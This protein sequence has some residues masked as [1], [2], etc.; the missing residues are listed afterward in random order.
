MTENERKRIAGIIEA[1]IRENGDLLLSQLKQVLKAKGFSDEFLSG[2]R[3]KTWIAGE[4]PEFTIVGPSGGAERIAIADKALRLI[5][6][7]VAKEG[8]FL[9]SQVS[10]LLA[11]EGIDWKARANGKKLREWITSTYPGVFEVSQ[12]ALW[13]YPASA[14]P[15]PAPGPAPAPAPASGPNVDAATKSYAYQFCFFPANPALLRQVRE[16]TG[17]EAMSNAKWAAHR[18][19]ALAQCLLGLNGGMLDDSR[20]ESPR[21]AFR[22][23]L[24][25]RHEQ[26]IYGIMAPNTNEGAS[27]KWIFSA[28]A[29]PGQDTEEGYWLCNTFG[30]RSQASYGDDRANAIN[31]VTDTLKIVQDAQ[32]ALSGEFASIREEVEE[33]RMLSEAAS[34]LIL[35]YIRGWSLLKKA[36]EKLRES[37]PEEA[38]SIYSVQ[39]L[40]DEL[41]DTN[42]I[43]DELEERFT[44][45]ARAVWGFLQDN[46]LCTENRSQDDAAAWSRILRRNLTGETRAEL[47]R[48]LEP[49][50]AVA[51]LRAFDPE[52]GS[53]FDDAEYSALDTV[54]EHFGVRLKLSQLRHSICSRDADMSFLDAIPKINALIL[55][56]ASRNAASPLEEELPASDAELLEAAM[57][58]DLWRLT[59]RVFRKPNRLETAVMLGDRE[60]VLEIIGDPEKLSSFGYDP[61]YEKQLAGKAEDLQLSRT[62]TPLHA[63]E[64]LLQVM[65]DS[66]EA[67]D[68]CLLLSVM[69]KQEGAAEVLV[70][71]YLDTG[72]P[73]PASTLFRASARTMPDESRRQFTLSLIQAGCLSA[74]EAI[75][76]DILVFLTEE[77]IRLLGEASVGEE[78][79]ERMTAIYEKIQPTP[80]RY[81]VFLNPELQSYILR[82]ENAGELK[83]Y[84][85]DTHSEK[86]AALLRQNAFERGST[87]LQ[88][89][90]RVHAFMGSWGDLALAFAQ[91]SAESPERQEF[92]FELLRE[93]GDELR[94]IR[95]LED[96]PA[97]RQESIPYYYELLF[98]NGDY[99]KLCLAAEES[100]CPSTR[101]LLLVLLASCRAGEPIGGIS[102]LDGAAA[103][104]DQLLFPVGDELYRRDPQLHREFLVK[105][106]PEAVQLFN[107]EELTHLVTADGALS[108]EALYRMAEDT[109]RACPPLALYCGRILGTGDFAASGSPYLE[110]RFGILPTLDPIGQKKAAHELRIL[111]PEKYSGLEEDIFDVML[112]E[113]LATETDADAKARSISGLLRNSDLGVSTLRHA[114]ARIGS[115]PVLCRAPLYQTLYA[116]MENDPACA[117]LF[118][119][120]YAF[121]DQ[122]DAEYRTFFCSR[123]LEADKRAPLP[124]DLL[125][126][127]ENSILE[128]SDRLDSADVR[129]CILHIEE[130]RGREPYLSFARAIAEEAAVS[131]AEEYYRTS[132]EGAAGEVS[133]LCDALEDDSVEIESYLQ[134]CARLIAS[135]K[136]RFELDSLNDDDALHALRRL[137]QDPMLPDNWDAVERF[138]PQSRIR[139]RGLA[140]Y[141][142]A[143]Y[144]GSLKTAEPWGVEDMRD[145][146]RGESRPTSAW[147]RC[148]NYCITEDLDDLFFRSVRS[149]LKEINDYYV[150]QMP[151]YATKSYMQTMQ[152]I[153]EDSDTV[154]QGEHA[155][156]AAFP[157]C[158]RETAV[159]FISEAIDVFKRIDR[160]KTNQVS[161]DDNHNS[162][163]VIIELSLRLGC[164][165]LLLENLSEELCGG[166][167]NL[168]LVVVCRL[169]LA[170]K[171]DTAMRFLHHII[172]AAVKEYNY[173]NLMNRLAAMD[174]DEELVRWLSIESNRATLR[175]ILPNGNAPDLLRLQT[176]VMSA[177]TGE[178]NT[179]EDCARVVE[180]LIDCYPRDVMC[181]KSLF[182]ICKED[183]PAHL[184]RIYRSLVGIYK[185]YHTKPR[186]MYTRDRNQILQ[187]IA[188]LQQVMEQLGETGT[189]FEPVTELI[190]KYPHENDKENPND[191]VSSLNQLSEDIRNLFVGVSSGSNDFTLMIRSLMGS[192]TENWAP[193]F[194]EAFKLRQSNWLRTYCVDKFRTT[195]G[196]LRGMLRVWQECTSDAEKEEYLAWIN[197]EREREP[198]SF[199]TKTG[200]KQ[201]NNLVTKV[202]DRAV[203]WT[204]LRL[205]WEEHL[206]CLG[207]LKELSRPEKNCC[208]KVMMAER[209]KGI[210]A[211]DSFIVMIRLAQDILK[212]QL[213]EGNAMEWFR[214]GD[215]DLAAAAYEALDITKIFPSRDESRK[216]AY[217]E[218]YETWLRLSNIFAGA[219]LGTKSCSPHSCMNMMVALINSGFAKHFDRL[220]P[221]LDGRNLKLFRVVRRILTTSLNDGEIIEILSEFYQNHER[222]SLIALL[223]FILSAN[224][225]GQYLILSS[226]DKIDYAARQLASLESLQSAY[227]RNKYWI[228]LHFRP[229]P[230]DFP[231][232]ADQEDDY[233][234]SEAMVYR[235]IETADA[236]FVPRFSAEI[237]AFAAEDDG[238]DAAAL[239]ESYN[240]LTPYTDSDGSKRLRLA[241]LLCLRGRNTAGKAVNDK[242]LVRF[243][244]NYYRYHYNCVRQGIEPEVNAERMHNAMLDLATYGLQTPGANGEIISYLPN[245]F[246]Y[247][248]R[249]YSTIDNLLQD[250]SQ[251][252]TAYSSI[253]RLLSDTEYSDAAN[254]LLE[255]LNIL[256]SAASRV[257]TDTL[258]IR[259]CQLAQARLSEVTPA[260]DWVE[261]FA[262]LNE[263]LRQAINRLD[264]RPSLKITLFNR[265]TGLS[266]DGLYGEI[267]NTGRETA[268]R[269]ELQATFPNNDRQPV[270]P[271]YRLPSLRPNEKAAFAVSYQ[272]S[273]TLNELEY[274]LN[275]SYS[276]K[277]TRCAAA[278]LH[279]R[280]TLL[281]SQI[282]EGTSVPQFNTSV[283]SAFTID[284]NGEIVSEDFK[285]RKSET[286]SLRALLA[287][288]D[289]AEYRSAIV[290]GIKR[291]GKTSLLNYLRA[292]IRAKKKENTVQLF[293][294][295]QAISR[296][297][298]YKAFFRSVLDELP[299]EFPQILNHPGWPDFVSRWK[300]GE[301]EEGDR[302]PADLSLFFRQLHAMM[303]GK[304]LYLIFDEFDVLIDRLAGD[305]GYDPL[306]QALRSLQMN[307]DCRDAVHLV[308]CGSNHLLIYNR[309]GSTV[310]QMFQSFEPIP[311]GQMLASDIQEMIRDWLD[312]YPFIR[313]AEAEGDGISPSIQ[314]IERYTGGLVWYTRLLVNEAVRTAFRDSRECV[315]PSDICTAFNSICCYN[316]CR[317]LA[318]GCGANEKIVLDAMQALA[319][320]PGMFV[321]Y[322]QLMQ[323]LD[324]T[325][326]PAQVKE[327]LDILTDSVQL[328]EQKSGSRSYRFRVEL[329]RRYFRTR[330][331]LENRESRFG[332]DKD[333][334]APAYRDCFVMDPT[335]VGIETVDSN[336]VFN[337][338][339]ARRPKK[340]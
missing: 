274:I 223:H 162:L 37:R 56:A 299:L 303:D 313:F 128:M 317:Q 13:V 301:E 111:D 59:A 175:F 333:D 204:M 42:Q 46:L 52:G 123:V 43:Q 181:Y 328:L 201:L 261:M 316:N 314:W 247:C 89:A 276:D 339:L 139:A 25:T 19:N 260:R 116:L 241:A 144:I 65:G 38:D 112:S 266:S 177:Y 183:Y 221:C 188:V 290:Q 321:S 219:G 185:Y 10:P 50:Q 12:D 60:T 305:T 132:D 215:Y 228:P 39:K 284:E 248:V 304:G 171:R 108:G 96:N 218:S 267:E 254:S 151:W 145:D 206:V 75:N 160:N 235:V 226:R 189:V 273:E 133:L 152:K 272:A 122:G 246:Q 308:L 199:F 94:M 28:V 100:G 287:G 172:S 91:F 53:V 170:D 92:L 150:Q 249:S 44:E 294:D 105:V 23:G 214:R 99:A 310:N 332:A 227:M 335:T 138:I 302:D 195:R 57:G 71:H 282:P 106:F 118:R 292:F 36:L 213:L 141:Y 289:F 338:F 78:V 238:S 216:E 244:I 209:L 18:T 286:Q 293:I 180:N 300:L 155:Q 285:G 176:L 307:P 64:R 268:N 163:R 166:Y 298:I 196:I 280:L 127:Y 271:L 80:I 119:A 97:L 309:T 295:C 319:A 76:E 48:Q 251:N 84:G 173:A 250:Y 164:E 62:I 6:D 79:K 72:R 153:L 297:C 229:L 83:E 245:W 158:G 331:W 283:A 291:S 198:D 239:L 125:I 322:E 278:P 1:W 256:L 4:F 95:F 296:P 54:N 202:N 326:T 135:S 114:S 131:D 149:W 281:P 143:L 30:I 32:K 70:R 115:D 148:V 29:F 184:S 113:L 324:G 14:V 87:P 315:Y 312:N 320:R 337:G 259:S 82:P 49:Y 130:R 205:P 41:N 47:R 69:Q 252:R 159:P 134:Y 230:S 323:L 288:D 140:L 9:L 8:R 191:I 253:I 182:I 93:Q 2:I 15:S 136:H 279:G 220:A 165:E 169:L 35:D 212:A 233:L 232:N 318:E 110:S 255:V 17:D 5:S 224:R 234:E 306:L 68:Q 269:L 327:S 129:S 186:S 88:T 61:A 330:E 98:R 264:L 167:I 24:K 104:E 26:D 200:S 142:Y 270:S 20:A 51:V 31:G 121:W 336:S 179:R 103:A 311:V 203:N 340:Q 7:A 192:V 146:Q 33:G 77:G 262:A 3:P 211:K 168:G 178:E 157:V 124:D 242:N 137:Y 85:M 102:G 275:L 147:K 190:W 236:D 109:A 16:L 237:E 156:A 11:G 334:G 161:G 74:E 194:R 55:Q 217:Y 329:Y 58:G 257:G 63:A 193:F 197:A 81:V 265:M 45:L 40:L 90:K 34:G 66:P 101:E 263:M 27:Q 107:E 222:S 225:A 258:D 243:G 126:E 22:T 210:S 21:L 174:T 231:E 207:N 120:A 86:L 187:L 240:S 117:D 277:E 208:Y 154:L 325:L 67:V 73:E